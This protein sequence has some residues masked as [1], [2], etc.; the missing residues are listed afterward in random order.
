[1]LPKH[2][3]LRQCEIC[4]K[5]SKLVDT[6]IEGS[7]LSVCS[8]CTSFGN[9]V[10]IPERKEESAIT[11]PKKLTLM[12]EEEFVKK[13]YPHLIKE[14]RERLGLK[15]K[16]LAQEIAEKESVIHKL[17]SGELEPSF[18]LAKKLENFLKIKLIEKHEEPKSQINLSDKSL[19]I[20]DLIRFKKK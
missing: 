19:T 6:I 20:G 12:K 15:Q 18:L 11:K 3:E 13:S 8:S 17:E 14:A 9:T 7:M 16:E 10:I 2:Q 1:M 4:G 5:T